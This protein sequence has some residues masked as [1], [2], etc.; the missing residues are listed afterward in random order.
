M[1]H[2]LFGS[3]CRNDNKS[4]CVNEPTGFF[5]QKSLDRLKSVWQN[6]TFYTKLVIMLLFCR[7]S[8]LRSPTVLCLTAWCQ[9]PTLFINCL[10]LL[11][12]PIF[13]FVRERQHFPVFSERAS[14]LAASL[15]TVACCIDCV[16][17]ELSWASSVN[18]RTCQVH[19]GFTPDLLENRNRIMSK[20][21][22]YLSKWI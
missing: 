6:Q 7:S 14:T 21:Q 13:V 16:H 15:A 3:I 12:C 18:T 5:I 10:S 19:P 22:D 11:L 1:L 20:L 4:S 17:P 8:G 9:C 2:D